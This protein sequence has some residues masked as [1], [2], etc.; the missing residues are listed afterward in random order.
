MTEAVPI[1]DYERF[2]AAL[3]GVPSVAVEGRALRVAGAGIRQRRPKRIA[4]VT[5]TSRR[6]PCRISSRG[7][8]RE[9]PPDE[10]A[11]RIPQPEKRT[12]A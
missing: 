3:T 1:T 4:A 8:V 12:G 2:L 9:G 5:A 11:G 10:V 7:G 6:R